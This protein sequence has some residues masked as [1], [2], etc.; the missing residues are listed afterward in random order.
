MEQKTDFQKMLESMTPEQLAAALAAAGKLKDVAKQVP[1]EKTEAQKKRA[2][3][4][5]LATI[6][7]K[8]LAASKPE[9]VKA[10]GTYL[11]EYPDFETV[12]FS[13]EYVKA[14]ESFKIRIR[15]RKAS[16]G[17]KKTTSGKSKAYKVA[18]EPTGMEWLDFES[19][20]DFFAWLEKVPRAKTP[21]DAKERSWGVRF[22]GKKNDLIVKDKK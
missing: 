21:K 4:D 22:W 12:S 1:S 18:G 7:T 14:L 20:D 2:A 8:A 3:N 11:T 15:G 6:L 9:L 10:I 13:V 5:K 16:T 19:S 17:E